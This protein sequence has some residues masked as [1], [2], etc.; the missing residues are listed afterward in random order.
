MLSIKFENQLAELDL[1]G[2]DHSDDDIRAIVA[3]HFDV[4]MDRVQA[5]EIDRYG[6]NVVFRPDAD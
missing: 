6:R 3:R 4:P 5:Y 1:D 2:Y